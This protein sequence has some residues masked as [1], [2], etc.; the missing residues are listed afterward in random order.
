MRAAAGEAVAATAAT[1]L[2]AAHAKFR[3][4]LLFDMVRS[5][6]VVRSGRPGAS[7]PGLTVPLQAHYGVVTGLRPRWGREIIVA[8]GADSP[9]RLRFGLLGPVEVWRDSGRLRL[10]GERQRAL[11]ALLLLQSNQLVRT[12]WLV[13]QLFGEQ[14]SDRALNAL[15][16]AIARLRRVLEGGGPVIETR[17]GGYVLTAGADQLDTARFE[18]LLDEGRGLLAVGDA[19]TASARLCDALGIWRGAPL[20]DL[21]LVECLQVEIRRLEELRQLALL[22]RI[23]ADLA[24]GAGGELVE[25]LEALIASDPLQERLRGQL[26]LAL[27]RAGR[28]SEALAVYRETSDLL[29]DE[30]GLEPVP[31]FRRW[32]VRSS[33]T[34]PRFN[35]VREQQP[36]ATSRCRP[37]RFS[38][39]HASCSRSPLSFRTP[40]RDW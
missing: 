31:P 18:R 22:E 30:L 16:V 27:Y 37:H 10:G 12:E 26:M 14:H 25:E 36:P 29:R 19:A 13:T 11:L 4:M 15:R 23:D 7:G 20:A 3:R 32:S 34:M 5:F 33:S 24:L 17:P 28:Q 40:R 1:A 39:A 35:R 8:M 38:A 6:R 9:G 2:T 21:A